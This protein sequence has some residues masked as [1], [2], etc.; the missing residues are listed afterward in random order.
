MVYV[1]P[2]PF[3][4][5]YS[6]LEQSLIR[7]EACGAW[8]ITLAGSQVYGILL[9]QLSIINR[10]FTFGSVEREESPSSRIL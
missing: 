5:P 3:L 1:N 8:Q 10:P 6:G 7:R 4:F 2:I 9:P